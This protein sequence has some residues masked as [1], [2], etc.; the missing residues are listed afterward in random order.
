MNKKIVHVLY[1]R[2]EKEKKTFAQIKR[3]LYIFVWLFHKTITAR[4]TKKELNQSMTI[5]L[6]LK[7][8]TLNNFFTLITISSLLKQ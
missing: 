1:K 6:F 5:F 4:K 3:V 2:E 8:K 7:T